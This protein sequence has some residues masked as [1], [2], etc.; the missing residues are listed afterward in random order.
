MKGIK[1]ISCNTDI[2]SKDKTTEFKCPN[3][4]KEKI[5]RCGHCRSIS[6]E[7]KCSQCEFIGP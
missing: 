1:C 5:I 3:C 2:S 4:G 6:A 7:Y